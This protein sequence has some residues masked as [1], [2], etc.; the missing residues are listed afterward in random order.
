MNKHPHNLFLIVMALAS[1]LIFS[2][3]SSRLPLTKYEQCI[4][5]LK[6]DAVAWTVIGYVGQEVS[7]P[8]AAAV[9]VCKEIAE[10]EQRWQNVVEHPDLVT[11]KEKLRGRD[12]WQYID[13]GVPKSTNWRK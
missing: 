5:S 13:E 7:P 9:Q 4:H 11:G 10:M 8:T 2:R 1:I 12:K 3:C 6:S